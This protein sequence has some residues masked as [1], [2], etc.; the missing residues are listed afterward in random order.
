MEAHGHRQLLINDQRRI[1]ACDK[2]LWEHDEVHAHVTWW[3]KYH[4]PCKIFLGAHPLK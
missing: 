2:K 3:N 1:K 4:Y